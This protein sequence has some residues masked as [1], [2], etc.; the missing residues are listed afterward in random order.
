[1]QTQKTLRELF[2]EVEKMATLMTLVTS[3]V[4]PIPS[5]VLITDTQDVSTTTEGQ[6]NERVSRRCR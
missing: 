2:P 3:P 6:E 4:R 1:M 5:C